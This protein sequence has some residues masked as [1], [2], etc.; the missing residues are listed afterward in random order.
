MSLH[1]MA[2]VCGAIRCESACIH[3]MIWAYDCILLR[4]PNLVKHMMQKDPCEDE[5]CLQK[6]T[7]AKH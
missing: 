5:V 4:L 3:A 6:E 7:Y 1:C 2:V